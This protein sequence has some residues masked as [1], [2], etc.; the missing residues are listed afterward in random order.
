M[1]AFGR[2]R[3]WAVVPSIPILIVAALLAVG[4]LSATP[5]GAAA[6]SSAGP[7]IDAAATETVDR[8][9][10]YLRSLPAFTV[11]A[12]GTKEEIVNRDFKLQ[13]SIE[14]DI[15]VKKPN[16]LRAFGVG[17][18]G[19][20]TFVYDGKSL[21]LYLEPDNYLATAPA[22]PTL[23]E[24]LDAMLERYGVELPLLDI[25][26]VATGG[27]LGTKVLESS[28][29]G[30]SRVAGVECEHLAF[31]GP[32]ADWQIWVEQGARPLPRKLV[33]TTRDNPTA[34]QFSALLSWDVS[35]TID[36]TMF[37][38]KPP[39]GALPIPFKELRE[40]RQPSKK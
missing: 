40:P 23:R 9:K 33:I 21:A 2:P 25:L 17:D 6:P 22:P 27:E 1:Q 19:R 5:A 37:Q 35:P 10:E 24:M 13:R 12:Q 28:D 3:V 30:R 15:T 20:R 11:H 8:M 31:R 29:I 36:E 14:T 39:P 18:E 26:Y 34:P 4:G 32:K 7:A 16:R 38:L